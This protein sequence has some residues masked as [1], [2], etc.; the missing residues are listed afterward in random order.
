M[1]QN[2]LTLIDGLP[3]PSPPRHHFLS[4][5]P[6]DPTVLNSKSLSGE[7]LFLPFSVEKRGREGAFEIREGGSRVAKKT[8]GGRGAYVKYCRAA[9]KSRHAAAA[10]GKVEE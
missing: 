10:Q 7:L 1:N 3:P 8:M 6:S 2:P 5:A 9:G 4:L